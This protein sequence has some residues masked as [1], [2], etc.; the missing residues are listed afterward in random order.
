VAKNGGPDDRSS[1][2]K[3]FR[4]PNPDADFFR[5]FGVGCVVLFLA[6]LLLWALVT[7]FWLR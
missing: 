6:F 7:F 3:E 2:P 4:R 1:A 5:A